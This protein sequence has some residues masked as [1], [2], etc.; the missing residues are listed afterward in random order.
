MVRR[1]VTSF[2]FMVAG[3]FLFVF[4]SVLMVV[5]GRLPDPS[6]GF[7]FAMSGAL[8]GA[9]AAGVGLLLRREKDKVVRVSI[10]VGA[11]SA[12]AFAATAAVILSAE[13][14]QWVPE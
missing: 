12:L 14:E 10:A 6:I 11:W 3:A 8:A 7:G 5:I 1:P 13:L 4:N 9:I 2:V